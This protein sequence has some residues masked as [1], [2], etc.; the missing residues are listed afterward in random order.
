[1]S[2][3]LSGITH[4]E[5]DVLQL[6][7]RQDSIAW[8]RARQASSRLSKPRFHYI[9]NKLIQSNLVSWAYGR[10]SVSDR[11]K[12]LLEPYR[13]K[14]AV[15][16]AAGMG[17]RMRPVTSVIPKPMVRVKGKRII[18]TQLDALLAA[19]ITD[20]T[21]VRGYQGH[22]FNELLGKYPMIQFIDNPSWESAGAIVSVELAVSL[23]EGAY[24]IEADLYINNPTI[25]RSYE[26]YSS[27]CGVQG[28]VV[29][30]WHFY[31]DDDRQIA[32]LD[33]GT[34]HNSYGHSY[35]FVGIMHWSAGDAKQLLGDLRLIMQDP[36]NHQRFIESVPFDSQSGSYSIYARPVSANDVFE[37]DTYKELQQL[38]SSR[39]KTHS[40]QSPIMATQGNY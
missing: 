13:V 33:H 1:M 31:T 25:L 20:I 15:I 37:L 32:C 7:L 30:D 9:L 23:L 21:I 16:L 10:Y 27:Y 38:R 35:R 26:F 4:D 28:K 36:A 18:E 12:E 22:V 34:S 39:L 40:V 24:V 17:T 2:R 29:D 6:L 14:R 5:L 11:A 19:G 3:G 8:P